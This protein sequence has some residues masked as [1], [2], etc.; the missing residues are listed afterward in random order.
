MGSCCETSSTDIRGGSKLKIVAVNDHFLPS[1]DSVISH[2]YEI[3]RRM[4]K[5][6]LD[7]HIVTS[8]N[9][10]SEAKGQRLP[11]TTDLPLE[12]TI[13]GMRVHRV[14]FNVPR[15]FLWKTPA[16]DMR[17]AK[18]VGSKVKELEPDIVHFHE[19][20]F[21]LSGFNKPTVATI[22]GLGFLEWKY[23]PSLTKAYWLSH[24][25]AELLGFRHIDLAIAVSS[26]MAR[27]VQRYYRQNKAVTIPNGVD[28]LLFN[29][30]V[31]GSEVKDEFGDFVLFVGRLSKSKGIM[32]LL[33][34]A[35][36]LHDVK[37]V[38]IGPS[39][40]WKSYLKVAE[41]LPNVYVVGLVPFK[42][43]LQFYAA[44]DV[45]VIPSLF[46]P[47]PLVALEAGSMGKPIVASEVGGIPEV[48]GGACLLARPG[49]EMDFV[50]KISQLLTDESLARGLSRRVS[51]RVAKN[52]SWDI[53]AERTLRFYKQ[54]VDGSNY[55]PSFL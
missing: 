41:A 43:L 42:K 26:C 9:V 3:Y 4:V 33:R 13:E 18:E 39:R 38:I 1:R 19:P 35:Q 44:C 30:K 48:L 27:A 51:E 6:G 49:D 45:V 12:E 53:V 14:H 31:D 32:T 47:C 2:M 54:L 11:E 21:A 52:F 20:S 23:A 34:V 17:F 16:Y 10:Y 25:A 37:F 50:R 8:N 55:F 28:L 40:Q 46:D 22:H 29:P 5:S 24:G 15:S 36:I 7:I